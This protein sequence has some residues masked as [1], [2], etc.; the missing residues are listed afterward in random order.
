MYSELHNKKFDCLII[1]TSLAE[2]IVSSYMCKHGK[3]VLHIESNKSYGGDCKN[4]NFVEFNKFSTSLEKERNQESKIDENKVE[5]STNNTKKAI[6]V[7]YP[8]NEIYYPNLELIDVESKFPQNENLRDYNLDFNL[9]LLYAK[10]VATDELSN[11][12][13]SNYLEFMPIKN[14]SIF[15]E[16]TRIN[17]PTNKSEIFLSDEL[18]LQEKQKLFNFLI[19]I[20][21]IKPIEDDLN[22]TDDF[23]KNSEVENS[24][25]AN[26][27]SNFNMKASEFLEKNFN[28]KLRIIVNYVLGCVNINNDNNNKK[29][30]F[31]EN[32]SDITVKELVDSIHKYL[33]SV[34]VFSKSP[35][36]YPIYGSSEF[37]QAMC[38]MASIYQGIFII[39]NTLKIN[40]KFNTI[41][42]LDSKFF[43]TIFDQR[44]YYIN[45]L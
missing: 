45:Y 39:N 38:R 25:V 32:D 36:L 15:F 18:E 43:V 33:C 21:K 16:G 4:M 8:L 19:A 30:F 3:K 14:F 31:S 11:S 42:S 34:N 44:K 26:L 40:I 5:E 35:F 13:A 28:P 20:N 37:S 1:G 22:H 10:S 2:S 17:V 29:D 23:K 12:K 6:Q 24:F 27:T 7:E 9:K 41:S